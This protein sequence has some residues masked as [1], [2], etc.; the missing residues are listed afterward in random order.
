MKA[1]LHQ[2]KWQ[3][4]LLSKWFK[5]LAPVIWQRY[6]TAYQDRSQ[7]GELGVLDAGE[8]GCFSS[9]ALVIQAA[10]NP[11]KDKADVRDGVVLTT[12]S[13][14]YWGGETS[15]L[16]WGM[17][18]AQ[19]PGDILIAP[20]QVLTHML[21][22]IRGIRFGHVYTVHDEVLNPRAKPYMCDVCG[23]DYLGKGGLKQHKAERKDQA[24]RIARAQVA[25]DIHL[26]ETGNPA[27]TFDE[28]RNSWED[29]ADKRIP[30]EFPGCT[31]DFATSRAMAKHMKRIHGQKRG[32][33]GK[34]EATDGAIDE[35]GDIEM[36]DGAELGNVE[37]EIAD[38]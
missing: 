31:E 35:A 13:G 32:G 36:E 12:P 22:P 3:H 1:Y 14:W 6:W 8:M 18:F 37:M 10:V 29:P 4:I 11:H 16:E 34:S 20:M 25:Y 28:F 15:I 21:D 33:K 5:A 2:I 9:Y 7:R 26:N 27:L 38:E 17:R 23:L 19:Q 24:H 30:C